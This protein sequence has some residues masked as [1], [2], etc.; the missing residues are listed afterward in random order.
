MLQVF[1]LQPDGFVFL[2]VFHKSDDGRDILN[3]FGKKSPFLF[4]VWADN[5]PFILHCHG[6]LC[7]ALLDI[8]LGSNKSDSTDN[9]LFNLFLP[10]I[11]RD[12][13][14]TW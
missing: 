6:T 14:T 10:N 11:T 13:N 5:M 3:P 12:T 8:N 2:S 4:R 1:G 7:V 9:I